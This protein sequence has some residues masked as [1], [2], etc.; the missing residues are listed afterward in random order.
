M[1][2]SVVSNYSG[3]PTNKPFAVIKKS[4]RKKVG[5]HP[6][7]EKANQQIA[8]LNAAEG[9]KKSMD[10]A[11]TSDNTKPI[12]GLPVQEPEEEPQE[13]QEK[14]Q[15]EKHYESDSYAYQYVPYGVISFSELAASQK[16]AKASREVRNLAGQ[17]AGIVENIMA[18]PDIENKEAAL[19]TLSTEFAALTGQELKSIH[20]DD[21]KKGKG[22][23]QKVIDTVK[24][25]LPGSEKQPAVSDG[26]IIWKNANGRYEWVARYSNNIRDN[27]SP[28][29]IISA[30]SH[31]G[32]VDR[33]D[34]GLASLPELWIWHTKELKIGQANW[35]ATDEQKSIVYPLAGGLIDE[36]LEDVAE[37]LSKSENIGL[38]HG[39]PVETIKRDKN[40]PTIIVEHESREISIL[41][42]SVAAVADTEFFVLEKETKM[43]DANKKSM[44]T[45]KL[46]LS[47]ELLARIEEKNAAAA[48][49]AL[50]EQLEHKEGKTEPEA[51]PVAPEGTPDE[52]HETSHV[53]MEDIAEALLL[54]KDSLQEGIDTIK[55]Q[56]EAFV[57]R[58]D[59]LERSDEEKI[60]AK[61]A[62]TPSAS[63]Q[64][65]VA[66]SII[67]SKGKGTLVDGRTSL[68]KEGPDEA[69]AETPLRLNPI[70]FI[71][72]MLRESA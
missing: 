65:M 16:A 29:E 43:I 18:N 14:E 61:V 34:K 27:D 35:V 23:V 36:G 54:V 21:D 58:I 20:D 3:C 38:S 70:P 22:V 30:K 1:P 12:E 11:P 56:Q 47:P 26:M 40:D 48:S 2:W 5:C 9:A 62:K 44:L 55:A 49:K 19:S 39:M 4:D 72:K 15:A 52:S 32:F 66:Q 24:S 63:L 10:K 28:R 50:D 17:F 64:A 60:A 41:P 46:G 42:K 25:V 67:G 68:A 37:V 31:T 7:R 53:K 8:A 51:E 33:V 69:P 13:T 59:A 6:S 57:A 71:D 45:E